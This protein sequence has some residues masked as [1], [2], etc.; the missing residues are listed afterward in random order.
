[1][2]IESSAPTRVDLAGGT[3][4]I[5]PLYL[6]HKNP[7]TVN[8]AINQY[9]RVSLKIRDD[10]KIHIMSKDRKVKVSFESIAQIHHNH[11]NNYNHQT[12]HFHLGRAIRK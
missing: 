6:F 3:L 2:I 12:N 9:A 10:K 4:D 7:V 5:Y 11:K 1:M 8:F